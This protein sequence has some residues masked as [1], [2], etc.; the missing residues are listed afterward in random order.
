MKLNFRLYTGLYY[1]SK[2]NYKAFEEMLLKDILDKDYYTKYIKF[3]TEKEYIGKTGNLIFIT[4]KG[5]ALIERKNKEEVT[6]RSW[7][8][9]FRKLFP[10]NRMGDKDEVIAEMDEF[11]NKYDFTKEEILDA[12]KEYI[13]KES[14]TNLMYITTS[15]KFIKGTSKNKL[16]TY[17]E[18][19]RLKDDDDVFISNGKFME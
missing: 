11:L 10:S 17:C 14:S 19:I 7:I 8:N 16:K 13:K 3:L 6:S 1:L 18:F 2:G 5:L 9:E 15:I 12:T 4:K